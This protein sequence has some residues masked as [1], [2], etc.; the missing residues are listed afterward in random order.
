MPGMS[1]AAFGGL[2]AASSILRR[3]LLF[4]LTKKVKESRKK[5]QR[6]NLP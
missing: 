6:P 1:G 5:L 2:F 4:D 3:N